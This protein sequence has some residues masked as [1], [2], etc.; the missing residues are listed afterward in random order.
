MWASWIMPTSLA[1]SPMP[2]VVSPRPFTKAVTCAFCFGET[3][4]HTT[5]AHLAPTCI[6]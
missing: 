4:Q 6:A 3:L 2:R 5:A 1:P